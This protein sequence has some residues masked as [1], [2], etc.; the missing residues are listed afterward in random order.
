MS[1]TKNPHKSWNDF[2]IGLTIMLLFA[3]FGT[4]LILNYKI[5]MMLN[6]PITLDF[7]NVKMNI[8]EGDLKEFL[9]VAQ[10]FAKNHKYN[11]ETY[12]CVDYSLDLKEI[13]DELGF[14]TTV[15]K[16]CPESKNETCHQWLRMEIDFSP[17]HAVFTD[18]SVEYPKQVEVKT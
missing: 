12:N 8:Q 11:N 1:K 7:R 4:T 15:I 3:S 9:I 6:D 16:G 5:Y 10:R 14:R 2:I 18:F 13:T 17:Q